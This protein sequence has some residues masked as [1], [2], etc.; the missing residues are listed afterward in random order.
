ME[1]IIAV[2][3]NE[4][5]SAFADLPRRQELTSAIAKK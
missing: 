1:P 4:A 2:I 3:V 5:A